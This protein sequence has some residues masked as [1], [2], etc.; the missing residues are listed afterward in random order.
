MN[1]FVRGALQ[2]HSEDSIWGVESNAIIFSLVVQVLSSG[3]FWIIPGSPMSFGSLVYGRAS[4]LIST[5]AQ[6]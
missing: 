3:C 2:F 4:S 6:F 1:I 5:L